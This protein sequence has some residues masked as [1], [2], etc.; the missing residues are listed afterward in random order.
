M[1]AAA[2]AAVRRPFLVPALVFVLKNTH[3]RG[4]LSSSSSSSPPSPKSGCSFFVAIALVV[5]VAARTGTGRGSAIGVGIVG[6]NTMVVVMV[7]APGAIPRVCRGAVGKT[8]KVVVVVVVMRFQGHLDVVH[9][10]P[11]SHRRRLTHHLC[12]I[13]IPHTTRTAIIAFLNN[14]TTRS[15]WN[16]L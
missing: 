13:P 15:H 14:N 16:G 3:R 2:A 8:V 6:V 5:V 10:P 7:L 9:V 4:F 11:H 12:L 1:A